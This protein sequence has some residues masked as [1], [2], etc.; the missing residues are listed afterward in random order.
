MIELGNEHFK[1]Q[2]YEE[3]IEHY[4]RAI[5]M[6]PCQESALTNR[7]MA[8]IKTEQ[9][10]A[11]EKDCNTVLATNPR[12]VKA[13]YRRGLARYSLDNYEIA[14]VDFLDC[15]EIEPDNQPAKDFVHKIN[16]KL[17]PELEG[18]FQPVDK[19]QH[20]MSKKPL[21]KVKIEEVRSGSGS[22]SDDDSKIAKSNTEIMSEIFET[23]R[24]ESPPRELKV[25]QKP[26]ANTTPPKSPPRP[27]TLPTVPTTNSS[28]FMNNWK[29]LKKEPELFFKYFHSIPPP[30][31]PKLLV[32]FLENDGLPHL[33]RVFNDFYI[34]N[35]LTYLEELQFITKVPRFNVATMFLS[36]EDKYL[37]QQLLSRIQDPTA[38]LSALAKLYDT[39][40]H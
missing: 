27:V 36:K 26:I 13:L 30:Q 11:A 6:D 33:L 38:D 4:S 19:P 3:A 18:R 16:V 24:K 12:N 22:E 35:N 7:A 9:Y 39:S 34:P 15:L 20:L 21:V 28:Q 5:R 10:A 8:F 40:L 23:Q 29:T 14:K 37:C 17:N 25:E 2:K 1:V 31:Y 32:Q